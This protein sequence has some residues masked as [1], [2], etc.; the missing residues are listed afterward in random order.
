MK[1]LRKPIL[2]QPQLGPSPAI[3]VTPLVD[4]V[5]VLL[6][7]FMVLTP[8]LEKSLDVRVPTPQPVQAAELPP[9]QIVVRLAPTGA[10][11]ING[12]SVAAEA[13]ISVLG[14]RLARQSA[15]E[16]VVVFSA[17]DAA[18]YAVLVHAFD[19]ARQAGARVVGMI[20]DAP[21]AAEAAE[22][23][24]AELRSSPPSGSAPSGR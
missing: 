14:Q 15:T 6:I 1:R 16:R 5:L 9:D 10:L 12:E 18:D 19:G 7:I 24:P 23:A 17:D 8:L 13:Y 11:S 3:N 21:E 20:T 2:V 22:A 4:V